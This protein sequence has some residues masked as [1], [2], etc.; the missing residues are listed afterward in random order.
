MLIILAANVT[1]IHFMYVTNNTN[2][3]V[4]VI[5]SVIS[6]DDLDRLPHKDN[7]VRDVS[8]TSYPTSQYLF[9]LQLR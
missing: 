6:I 9:Q 3:Y 4:F 1:D 5:P 8:S 7:D 2:D